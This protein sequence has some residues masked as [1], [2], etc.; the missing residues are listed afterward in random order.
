MANLIN[1]NLKSF[2]TSTPTF[3][4]FVQAQAAL[5]GCQAGGLPTLTTEHKGITHE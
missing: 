4:E 2:F 3:A 5:R 1:P